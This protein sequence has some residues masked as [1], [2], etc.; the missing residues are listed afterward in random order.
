MFT[1]EEKKCFQKIAALVKPELSPMEG[2]R[3]DVQRIKNGE[4][5]ELVA[6][7][8]ALIHGLVAIQLDDLLDAADLDAVDSPEIIAK[9][10]ELAAIRKR[11]KALKQYNE[12]RQKEAQK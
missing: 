12:K 7:D 8:I 9:L 1:D 2:F 3:R 10:K 11:H 6:L 5:Y 4:K